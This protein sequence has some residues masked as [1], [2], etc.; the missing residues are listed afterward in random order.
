MS[1][2]EEFRMRITGL[3][4]Q[5]VMTI[6]TV[7]SQAAVKNG[8]TVT[9]LDRLRSAMRL[10]PVHC[11]IRLGGKGFLP[12]LS[13]GTAD[14]V[15]GLEPYE[16]CISSA[17]L[18]RPGGTT[19][20]NSQKTLPMTNIAQGSPYPDLEPIIGKLLE[21]DNKVIIL[22]ASKAARTITGKASGTNF[23]LLGV[24]V[25][26]VP[27]FPI[28]AEQIMEVIGADDAK[29]RCFQAGLDLQI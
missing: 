25:S 1:R 3:G 22:Y 2:A 13:P 5:G 10:G 19:I 21:H 4:G 18:L 9:S 6:A 23:V 12:T 11:D 16:G 14:V 8:L 27:Q 24:L 29:R 28:T 15:L 7:I 20:I 26:Q 17:Q